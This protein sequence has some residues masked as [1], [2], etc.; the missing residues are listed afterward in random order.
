MKLI[1]KKYLITTAL[2]WVCCFILFFFAYM[3]VLAPQAK[4][5]KQTSEQLAEK[6]QVYDS[7]LKAAHEETRIRINKEIEHLRNK[8]KD[9]VV[10]SED[11]T[12]LTFDISQIANEK[13]VGSFSVKSKD[14]HRGSEIPNCKH[15]RQSH[16][17]VSFTADFSQF[18]TFL[19]ALERHRP[20]I[21]VDKFTIARSDREDSDHK[22]GMNLSVFVRSPQ[23]S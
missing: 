22:V 14:D 18:A 10:D 19:N 5:K 1:H 9:F 15:V 4:S 8:L 20:F 12:N 11:S 21:F 2:I 13:R 3:L 16:I 17:D 7:A 6:K 23:G